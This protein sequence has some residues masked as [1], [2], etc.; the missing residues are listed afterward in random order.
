MPVFGAYACSP[1][2]SVQLL[3]PDAVLYLPLMHAVQVGAD[4]GEYF[5]GM[6]SRQKSGCVAAVGGENRPAAQ[7]VHTDCLEVV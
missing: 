1:T 3:R 5:P 6:H 7:V 2:H 4:M